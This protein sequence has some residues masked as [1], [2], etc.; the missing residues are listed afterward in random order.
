MKCEKNLAIKS[1]RINNIYSSND[2]FKPS[3]IQ[4]SL[5]LTLFQKRCMHYSRKKCAKGE[6]VFQKIAKEGDKSAQKVFPCLPFGK[7]LTFSDILRLHL[8]VESF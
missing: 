4:V 3:F 2:N 5:S 1:S 8:T 6:K 7:I